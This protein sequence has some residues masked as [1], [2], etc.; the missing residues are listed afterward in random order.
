MNAL[1]NFERTRQQFVLL[2]GQIYFAGNSLGPAPKAVAK[3]VQHTIESE[4]GSMLVKAWNTAGWMDQPDKL[5]NRLAHIIGATPDTVTTGDTLSIKVFQALSSAVSMRPERRVILSDSG[6]FPTDLYMAGGLV[7]L[8]Q[9]DYELRVVAPEE[10]MDAL[11]DD[12]AV[13]MLTQVDY[14]T[15]RLHDMKALTQRAHEVGALTV[16]DLAHSAGAI[17][18]NVDTNKADFA[19][20][21]T[22]KF[23]NAGP[24]SPAFIY[25]APHLIDTASSVLSGWLGHAR[26]FA[27]EPEYQPAVGIRHFRVGTPSVLSM[28]SL[29]AALDVWDEVD[30]NEVHSRSIELSE[31]FIAELAKRCPSLTLASPSDPYQ[32]GSQVSFKCDYG[33]PLMQA[34]IA[35]QVIGDFRAPDIVRFGITPLFLNEDDILKAVNIIQNIVDSGSWDKSEFHARKAVT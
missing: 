5:G 4:W 19:V 30:I 8:L 25:V 3:R 31:L 12:V 24:G 26:P 22:Y 14:R 32:R 6:N 1:N 13:V 20:G 10:V 35:A 15:G 7:N 28:A 18:T 17:A 21:C 11:N 23:L 33:Y 27:F 2:E 29:D 34:L 16:W 9:S